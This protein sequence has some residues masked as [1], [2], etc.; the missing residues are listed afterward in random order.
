ML[1][2]G[3]GILHFAT[4]SEK[5]RYPINRLN[6]ACSVASRSGSLPGETLEA[7][8]VAREPASQIQGPGPIVFLVSQMR[9]QNDLMASSIRKTT[10]ARCISLSDLDDLTPL[11]KGS[12]TRAIVL[13]DCHGKDGAHCLAAIESHRARLAGHMPLGLFNVQPSHGLNQQAVNEGI[14]GFFYEND[15]FELI[16]KG[17]SAM[18]EGELWMPRV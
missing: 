14:Q 3:W 6:E 7:F 8:P 17:V 9:L 10:G 5:E 4:V 2:R 11:G 12:D 16:A 1:P 18:F 15:P 13:W